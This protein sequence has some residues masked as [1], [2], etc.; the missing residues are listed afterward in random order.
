V[1]I[2]CRSLAYIDACTVYR[3]RRLTDQEAYK[4]YG[5]RSRSR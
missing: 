3:G 1:E 5:K 4:I 2:I